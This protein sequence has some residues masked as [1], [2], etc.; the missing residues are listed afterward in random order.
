[1]FELDYQEVKDAAHRD[2]I[3]KRRENLLKYLGELEW[4]R[5]SK[6]P[7]FRTASKG[8]NAFID[9][10]TEQ[11]TLMA[12][13]RLAQATKERKFG[14][15][16]PINILIQSPPGAGKS[17]LVRAIASKLNKTTE[18]IGKLSEINCSNLSTWAEVIPSFER[19]AV[20]HDNGMLPLAFFDEMDVPSWHAFQYMLMPMNEGAI[21]SNGHQLKFGSAVF[22]FAA[23]RPMTLETKKS[24]F[25]T[26]TGTDWLGDSK[27][28]IEIFAKSDQAPPKFAD[29]FSR[30]DMFLPLPGMRDHFMDGVNGESI[31]SQELSVI[32]MVIA[33][34][35][36]R[37]PQV[38]E[39]DKRVLLFLGGS[40]PD[41]KR[42][43]E[44]AIFQS[45]TQSTDRKFKFE[46]LPSKLLAGPWFTESEHV[47]ANFL[48]VHSFHWTDDMWGKAKQIAASCGLSFTKD[49]EESLRFHFLNVPAGISTCRIKKTDIGDE[50]DQAQIGSKNLVDYIMLMVRLAKKNGDEQI[51][52]DVIN[53]IYGNNEIWPFCSPR[54]Y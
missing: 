23:S 38:E 44:K 19:F 28:Q 47:D 30:I 12:S 3:K 21:I 14:A 43:L 53:E 51:T 17:S 15:Y 9:D 34:I 24:L 40:L 6:V 52:K 10:I 16:R 32:D 26:H 7:S 25:N 37:F 20:L 8:L 29:F 46:H 2:I 45:T 42:E 35:L 1:M 31:Y 5:A 39:V 48:P 22:F 4:Y 18:R 36:N 50:L 49:A 11:L 13:D 33:L 54:P 27:Q 41:S